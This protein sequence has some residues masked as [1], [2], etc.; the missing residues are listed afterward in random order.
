MIPKIPCIKFTETFTTK[1]CMLLYSRHG[2][3]TYSKHQSKK[4]GPFVQFSYT[5]HL[6]Q[7]DVNKQVCDAVIFLKYKLFMHLRRKL[8][9]DC[10]PKERPDQTFHISTASKSVD[11]LLS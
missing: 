6:M 4:I 11:P 1:R 3:F 2:Q 5:F 8:L 9:K 7:D 10:R